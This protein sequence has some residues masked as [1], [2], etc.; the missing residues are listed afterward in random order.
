MMNKIVFLDFDGV[1]NRDT[2]YHKDPIERALV[3]RVGEMVQRHDAQIVIS[4][5]WRHHYDLRI[6]RQILFQYGGIPPRRVIA[7]THVP[8]KQGGG[9][10][11]QEIAQWL[12]AHGQPVRLAILDDNHRGRF[13]MDVVRPWFVQT[14]PAKGVTPKD[15][16]Q[17]TALL[18]T[19][20]IYERQS[21]AAA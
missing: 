15:I 10:R 19:G 20:P 5:D 17:A 12:E 18:T 7:T 6:L 4:S 1:L 14:D 9:I 21:S 16:K 11:G 3:H 2:L 13:N 8:R